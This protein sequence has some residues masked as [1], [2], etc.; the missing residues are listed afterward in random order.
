M[1]KYKKKIKDSSKIK[2]T[3]YKIIVPSKKDKL[4]LQKCF[5]YLHN[6]KDLSTK[7]I[8]VNQL[9][10]EYLDNNNIIVDSEIYE[11]LKK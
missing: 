4:E 9:V 11:H 3:K 6:L 10:H 5:K 7:Y 2:F 8:V 1:K